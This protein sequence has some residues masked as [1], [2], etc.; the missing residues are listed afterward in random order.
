MSPSHFLLCTQLANA[1]VW[2]PNPHEVENPHINFD[3]AKS[4]LLIVCFPETSLIKTV[5]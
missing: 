5:V 4:E 3:S 1:R 2:E